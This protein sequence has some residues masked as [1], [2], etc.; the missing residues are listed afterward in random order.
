M[1]ALKLN[2]FTKGL[3]LG[4]LTLVAMLPLGFLTGAIGICAGP[5]STLNGFVILAVGVGGIAAATWAT[6]QIVYEFSNVD[7]GLRFVGALAILS[8]VAV[9][10]LGYLYST[11]AVQG[12]EYFLRRG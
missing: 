1:P 7:W 3:L 10:L 6:F 8:S 9:A 4:F 5:S 2:R 12:L 11:E